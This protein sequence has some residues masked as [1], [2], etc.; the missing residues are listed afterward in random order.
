[1]KLRTGR[2]SIGLENVPK[3]EGKFDRLLFN[4][5]I[6][7]H[8]NSLIKSTKK[9]EPSWIS[10]KS[11]FLNNSYMYMR[12]TIQQHQLLRALVLSLAPNL[13]EPPLI[14]HDRPALVMC[15]D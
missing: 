12:V 5:V 13:P 8:Y 11:G 9:E 2:L 4:G 1:M 3:E 7:K 15:C 6:L 14:C 10:P